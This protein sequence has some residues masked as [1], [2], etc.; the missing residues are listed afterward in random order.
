MARWLHWD[1]VN[2][3]FRAMTTHGLSRKDLVTS[4]VLAEGL[5]DSRRART[6]NGP[7]RYLAYTLRAFLLT[8]HGVREVEVRLDFTSGALN[9]EWRTSFGY[10]AISWARIGEKTV[11]TRGRRQTAEPVGGPEV[12]PTRP[13]WSQELAL[14]LTSGKEVVIR[15]NHEAEATTDG[16]DPDTSWQSG[17]DGGDVVAALRFLEAVAADGS[18]WVRREQRRRRH[19][20]GSG[21]DGASGGD[22]GAVR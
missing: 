10:R 3:R 18:G 22:G 7:M 13:V 9:D 14:T 16:D 2:L 4:F 15:A 19:R 8:E 17:E 1:R 6:G 20:A 5:R 12:P 21:G 11:R